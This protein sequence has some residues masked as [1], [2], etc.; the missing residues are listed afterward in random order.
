MLC[1]VYIEKYG[2]QL[3]FG[4]RQ[5][6][7]GGLTELRGLPAAYRTKNA[8]L[9]MSCQRLVYIGVLIP[10]ENSVVIEPE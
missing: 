4:A 1:N 10:R 8:S 2:L 3:I 6:N 7:L 9:Y 5:A